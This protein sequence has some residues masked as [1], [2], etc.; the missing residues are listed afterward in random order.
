LVLVVVGLDPDRGQ[1]ELCM[2]NL[3]VVSVPRSFTLDN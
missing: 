1:Y 2:Y 3:Y